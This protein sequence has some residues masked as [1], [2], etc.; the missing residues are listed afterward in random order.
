DAGFPNGE[1]FPVIRLVINRNETQ[2]RIARAVSRMWRQSLNIQTEIIVRESLDLEASRA[3]GDFDLLRR[4]VVIPTLDETASILTIFGPDVI[5]EV[6]TTA[7]PPSRSQLSENEQIPQNEAT[8]S[9]NWDL[10]EDGIL[11]SEQDA[12]N[13]LKAIPLYFPSSYSLVKPYVVNFE[14]NGLEAPLLRNVSIDSGWQPD[15][16]GGESN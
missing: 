9:P 3:A 5:A 2:L 13:E 15:A 12:L 14:M 10:A 1:N 8:P 7:S 16:V 6:T 4:N 11:L